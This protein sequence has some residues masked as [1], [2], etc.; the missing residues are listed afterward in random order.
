MKNRICK[1]TTC[2]HVQRAVKELFGKHCFQPSNAKKTPNKQPHKQKPTW[3]HKS[4]QG[5]RTVNVTCPLQGKAAVVV[6]QLLL[7]HTQ[8]PIYD[9]FL[10]KDIL[11]KFSSALTTSSQKAFPHS[12]QEQHI[13]MNLQTEKQQ[14]IHHSPFKGK[15]YAFA[16]HTAHHPPPSPSQSF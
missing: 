13:I 8:F 5:K 1:H 14:S 3:C 6:I 16:L 10:S 15:K 7:Y 11:P 9:P 2:L 12:S 4:Y